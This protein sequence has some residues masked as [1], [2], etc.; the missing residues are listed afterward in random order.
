MLHLLLSI[1]TIYSVRYRTD[2]KSK[3]IVGPSS[4]VEESHSKG[5]GISKIMTNC[6]GGG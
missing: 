3:K 1:Y 6:A 5:E 4:V 2:G